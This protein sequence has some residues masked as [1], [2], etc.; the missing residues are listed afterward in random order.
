MTGWANDDRL[1]EALA[2]Q[3]VMFTNYEGPTGFVTSLLAEAGV[4]GL[5]AMAVYGFAPNYIQG[6]PNPHVS[7]ALLR[8]FS[9]I[10]GVPLAAE[11][12]RSRRARLVA[13]GRPP[14]AGSAA[15][16]GAG[17]THAEPDECDRAAHRRG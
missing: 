10:T 2:R 9:G 8:T 15:V 5:P 17:R 3:N 4:R 11:R 14:A 6:V 7:H 16:A 12:S 1:R 13:S